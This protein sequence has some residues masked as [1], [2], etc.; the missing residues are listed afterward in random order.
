MERVGCMP[1]E[2][3]ALCYWRS[4][5][6]ALRDHAQTENVRRQVFI[7]DDPNHSM[8]DQSDLDFLFISYWGLDTQ[9]VLP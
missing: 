8:L 7:F 9:N 2:E 3:I 1:R 5:S 4:G 6:L